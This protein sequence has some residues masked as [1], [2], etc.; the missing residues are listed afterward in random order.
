MLDAE[1]RRPAGRKRMRAGVDPTRC[2]N[3]GLCVRI[4][5]AV[6]EFRPGTRKAHV[7]VA[8][9]PGRYKEDCRRAAGRCPSEA[10][11]IWED[12]G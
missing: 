2:D 7:K 12:I 5:P 3:T 9:V 1:D 10:I 8:T 6:F 11:R 4:C